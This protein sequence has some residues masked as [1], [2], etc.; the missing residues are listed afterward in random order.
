MDPIQTLAAVVTTLCGE[1][2]QL[3]ERIDALEKAQKAVDLERLL[4]KVHRP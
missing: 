4:D 3:R 2:V 1:I